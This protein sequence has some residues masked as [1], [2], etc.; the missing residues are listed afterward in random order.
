MVSA[1]GIRL[2]L[3]TAES[4]AEMSALEG[5]ETVPVSGAGPGGAERPLPDGSHPLSL[6]YVSFTSGSTGVPKGVAVPN[7]AVVRLV[8]A[9]TFASLGPGER[10]LQLAPVAFDASTLEI[11]GALL[12]GA[13][14]VVAPPGPL[15]LPEIAAL[16]RS[17]GVSVAWLTAGLFHQLAETD[18]EALGAVRVLLSGGDVLQPDRVRAVLRARDGRPLV[19]GYGPTENTTFTSCHVMTSEAQ[20]GA[21]V[22]IGQPI[23][24]TTVHVLDESGRPV[25]IGVTGELF[26]GGAGV[27]RGYVGERRRHGAGVRARPVRDRRTAVPDRG[28]GALARG[29]DA[30]VRWPG[31]RPG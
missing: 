24:G 18:V 6:A 28:P 21:S 7:Q 2:V 30:R 14:V 25:P 16:L 5:V 17:G 8:T 11:W 1:A 12:T 10:V 23:Q 19:N 9:P 29:R 4:S 13:A 26:A 15:G 22:P 31:R 3:V 20:L 27:A